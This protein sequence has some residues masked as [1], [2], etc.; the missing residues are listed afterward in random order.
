MK[1]SELN[2]KE[3]QKL[4]LLLKSHFKSGFVASEPN[5]KSVKQ[6][7]F[8]ISNRKKL[9]LEKNEIIEKFDQS[10]EKSS[11]QRLIQLIKQGGR[12]AEP[13]LKLL[14]ELI[15]KIPSVDDKYIQAPQPVAANEP[16]AEILRFYQ[17]IFD[18]HEQ[19]ESFHWEQPWNSQMV[20][21]YPVNLDGREYQGQNVEH[22]SA[23][24]Q[25][26]GYSVPVWLTQKNLEE[27]GLSDPRDI[28][29]SAQ[30][31]FA[32]RC[33][34]NKHRS[35]ESLLTSKAYNELPPSEQV[36]Y[37][38]IIVRGFY[39]VWHPDDI[40]ERLSD[41]ARRKMYGKSDYFTLHEQVKNNK[42]LAEKF[43]SEQC[44][45][46]IKSLY[47]V[48]RGLN[49]D[50]IDD[51][52]RCAY[53]PSSDVIMM[54][55]RERFVS[56]IGFAGTLA[57]ELIHSTGHKSRLARPGIT[58]VVRNEH[59]YGFE[60]L[61]AESG[62]RNY[63]LRYNLPSALDK[64]SA[65]YI[66]SWLNSLKGPKQKRYGLFD[67]A[68]KQGDTAAQYLI[69]HSTN[70]H[71]LDDVQQQDTLPLESDVFAVL[72]KMGEWKR[73]YKYGNFGG[74]QAIKK[75]ISANLTT[76]EKQLDGLDQANQPIK[77]QLNR[78]IERDFEELGRFEQLYDVEP[79]MS[80]VK[81]RKKKLTS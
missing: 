54:V 68:A 59:R 49:V 73:Q 66:V 52:E 77:E 39:P 62:A 43:Y 18:R 1:L 13:E 78:L 65:A 34:R 22:L 24:Q 31:V 76:I 71:S 46:A 7:N 33:Y 27:L 79:S 56:D 23:V 14:G 48:A 11:E 53:R 38:S 47:Q 19:G 55:P 12:V 64:E 63:L 40:S 28:P 60:E 80:L 69:K 9:S 37:Q 2:E 15:P 26:N 81:M 32:N 74:S 67:A 42:E 4:I 30:V 17:D 58:S 36:D 29:N 35:N 44:E 57:H 70:K 16:L 10:F 41:Q 25:L 61:V 8:F 6:L 72:R 75:E 21:G 3:T 20:Y 45:T 50:L 51:N 5:I